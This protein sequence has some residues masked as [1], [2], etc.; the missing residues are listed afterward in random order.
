MQPECRGL[1]RGLLA[2]G[3]DPSARRKSDQQCQVE[4][5][6]GKRPIREVTAPELLS[7]LRKIGG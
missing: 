7:A 2:D 3:V 6:A 5:F 4:T 1:A